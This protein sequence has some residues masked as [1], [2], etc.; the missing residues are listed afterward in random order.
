MPGQGTSSLKRSTDRMRLHPQHTLHSRTPGFGGPLG[1]FGISRRLDMT[2]EMEAG[3]HAQGTG[4]PVPAVVDSARWPSV[5]SARRQN[6]PAG[7]RMMTPVLWSAGM[8]AHAR[9]KTIRRNR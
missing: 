9:G 7:A 4:S 1:P 6:A 8:M 2:S 3:R 5:H